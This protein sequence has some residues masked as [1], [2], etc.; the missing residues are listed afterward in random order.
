[1][2]LSDSALHE[3]RVGANVK[4]CFP[5][6]QWHFTRQLRARGRAQALW[7]MRLLVPRMLI[8]R[9]VACPQGRNKSWLM[10]T[11]TQLGW[12]K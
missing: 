5:G 2:D 1:M 4:E 10:Q 11:F 7:R 3:E 12:R 6:A 8:N 9:D